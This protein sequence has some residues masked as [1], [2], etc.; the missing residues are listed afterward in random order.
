MLWTF[1]GMKNFR[2]F[3]N[4]FKIPATIYW[5]RYG[6]YFPPYQHFHTIIGEGIKG[7]N[8]FAEEEPSKQEID[9]VHSRYVKS[10]V[11]LYEKHK[12]KNGNVPFKVY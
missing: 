3:L 4:K 9:E 5:S 11:G 6:L 8:Y 2:L 7:R 1:D 10:L 12:E